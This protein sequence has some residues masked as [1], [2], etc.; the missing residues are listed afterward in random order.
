M[1][2][3][4]SG[5]EFAPFASPFGADP[6]ARALP[7]QGVAAAKI[8]DDDVSHRQRG[9]AKKMI[10][11]DRGGPRAVGES[12]VGFV[13]EGCRH[14]RPARCQMGEL[15]PRDRA[16][17]VVHDREHAIGRA[18][19]TPAPGVKETGDVLRVLHR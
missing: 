14:Q 8:V 10:P 17:I 1:A 16:E 18:R 11:I 4:S 15:P 12:Q 2:S 5:E 9:D 7:L 13:D 6:A 19:I 3:R